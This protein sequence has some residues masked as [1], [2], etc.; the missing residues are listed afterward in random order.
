MRCVVQLP[1]INHTLRQDSWVTM[2][3]AIA[4][5]LANA[6]VVTEL[7]RGVSAAR[8]SWLYLPSRAL[9][10]PPSLP[11]ILRPNRQQPSLTPFSSSLSHRQPH[12]SS[13]HLCLNF[14]R[15]HTH[16]PCSGARSHQRLAIRRGRT[17]PARHRYRSKKRFQ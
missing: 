4:L 10:T 11:P 17:G 12:P 9:L 13:P 2:M 8:I 5:A 7:R 14:F 15:W 6:G 16:C 3:F 1:N